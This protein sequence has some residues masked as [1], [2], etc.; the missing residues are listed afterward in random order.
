MRHELHVVFH[1]RVQGVGFRATLIEH[2]QRF[3][4]KGTA[5]NL[6]D[7]SVEVVVQGEKERLEQFLSAVEADPGLARVNRIEK[8]YGLANIPYTDF[9]IIY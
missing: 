3:G 8:K 9:H 5:K 4:L 7:G 2:A 6:S 1:G